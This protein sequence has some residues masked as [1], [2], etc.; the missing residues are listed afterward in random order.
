MKKLSLVGVAL[1]IS[2]ATELFNDAQASSLD[3]VKGVYLGLSSGGADDGK[4]V[5]GIVAG[6]GSYDFIYSPASSPSSVDF[7]DTGS[8]QISSGE[9]FAPIDLNNNLSTRV[10]RYG[11]LSATYTTGA[12]LS[13]TFVYGGGDST[14][15]TMGFT[16]GSDVTTSLASLGTRSFGVQLSATRWYPNSYPCN[17]WQPSISFT[18]NPVSGVLTG[19]IPACTVTLMGKGSCYVSGQ[20]QPAV[21]INAF[22]ISMS[23]GCIDGGGL[24]TGWD[25]GPFSGMAYFDATTAKLTMG[26]VASDNAAIGFADTAGTIVN[27]IFS[28][29]FD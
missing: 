27:E 2:L 5:L 12:L 19:T 23:F 17:S 6:D 13:P 18:I 1:L 21:G 7:M 15:S 29:T 28:G 10:A 11:T 4:L 14:T 24:P 16:S 9:F 20:V 22:L 25:S 26:A 3:T 8:G